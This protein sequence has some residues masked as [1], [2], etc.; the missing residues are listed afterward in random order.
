MGL[1]L[2]LGGL[3]EL[4]SA[5]L[6][7]DSLYNTKIGIPHLDNR[8]NQNMNNLFSIDYAQRDY[9]EDFDGILP[10]YSQEF[11]RLSDGYK[12]RSQRKS[13]PWGDSSD[14]IP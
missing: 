13:R 8:R 7:R 10:R 14:P 9:I 12:D 3:T 4:I 2:N 6:G 11:P 5:Y 1:K